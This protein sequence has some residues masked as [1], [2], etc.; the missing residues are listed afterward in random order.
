[1]DNCAFILLDALCR[2]HVFC[3]LQF[4][5]GKVCTESCK[6][7]VVSFQI[8]LCM[9]PTLLLFQIKGMVLT[10]IFLKVYM[11]QSHFTGHGFISAVVTQVSQRGGPG[12]LVYGPK[13]A[14]VI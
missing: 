14:T 12:L 4:C 13:L 6:R 9:H 8:S 7:N 5:V 1:M 2:H 11:L 3:M 10:A